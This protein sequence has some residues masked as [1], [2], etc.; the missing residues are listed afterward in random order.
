[1]QLDDEKPIVE[2]VKQDVIIVDD[3]LLDLGNKGK[4]IEQ[5]AFDD[6]DEMDLLGGSDLKSISTKS[7]NFKIAFMIKGG[8]VIYIMTSKI[9]N[10]SISFMK[11]Q[12][13]NLHTNMVSIAT[14]QFI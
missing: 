14:K 3:Y 12:L 13:H 9:K 4:S 1:M 7:G 2:E 6:E 5:F 8:T 10:D 11:K